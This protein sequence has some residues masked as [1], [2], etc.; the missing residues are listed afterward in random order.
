MTG[1]AARRRLAA[2]TGIAGA[3]L[4]GGSLTSPAGSPR[5]YAL[6]SALAGT[7]IAGGLASGRIPVASRAAVAAAPVRLV[8]EPAAVGAATFGLFYGA[9]RIA[10]K[11][12]VLDRSIGGVLRYVHEGS[13]PLVLLT[14][15]VNGAAEE[16]FFHGALWDL[17]AG[18]RP[19]PRTAAAYATFTAAARN[20]ALLLGGAVTSVIFGLERHRSGGVLAPAVAHVTWSLLMLTYLPPLYRPVTTG[21]PGQPPA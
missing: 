13:A 8:A 7:W 20:P 4:L 5:F 14:T 6:T 21:R 3:G 9:A 18:H 1:A 12:P 15:A 17:A 2:A 19:L 10:R 16:V 11:V